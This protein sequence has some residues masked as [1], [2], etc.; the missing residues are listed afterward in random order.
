MDK[1]LKEAILLTIGNGCGSTSFLQRKM[2]L[3]Y[4]QASRLMDQMQEMGVIG[5]F[6][7]AKPRQLLINNIEDLN[8][9]YPENL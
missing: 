6:E 2:K 7:G 8:D 4:N 1:Q 3:N 9:L 5:E